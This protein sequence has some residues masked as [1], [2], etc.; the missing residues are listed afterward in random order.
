MIFSKFFNL[1]TFENVEKNIKYIVPSNPSV[2]RVID[3][4]KKLLENTHIKTLEQDIFE[5]VERFNGYNNYNVSL[6]DKISRFTYTNNTKELAKYEAS[7]Y[8][9]I[10]PKIGLKEATNA[11]KRVTDDVELQKA[12]VDFTRQ[13]AIVVRTKKDATPIMRA[14]YNHLYGDKENV[15]VL[16]INPQTN[17]GMQK[18]NSLIS[19]WYADINGL[20]PEKLITLRTD[21]LT[22]KTLKP[23]K[24][25]KDWV[26]GTPV[27]K[28]LE[29]LGNKVDTMTMD[30]VREL[31]DNIKGLS[32]DE[33]LEKYSL[34]ELASAMKTMNKN[35]IEPQKQR[36]Y[37]GA[38]IKQLEKATSGRNEVTVVIPDDCSLSG[39]SML[40]DSVKIFD[41][42]IKDNPEKKVHV[43]FSPLILGDMAHSAFG[44]FID[45]S[46]PLNEMFLRRISAIKTDG[47][48]AFSGAAKAFERVRTAENVT[49]EVTPNSLKAKHFTDTEYFKNLKDQNLKSNLLYLMQGPLKNGYP[50]FGGFGNCGT[51]VITPTHEFELAG[52]KYAGKI[53]TNSVGFMETIGHELGVL[54]DGVSGEKGLFTKGT[55]RGYSRYSEWEGLAYPESIEDRIPIKVSNDGT[56][57]I[58]KS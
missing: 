50:Q 29:R 17:N 6:P 15:F 13:E 27:A 10:K 46:K 19:G 40:C 1:A 33:I 18:S 58:R 8:R 20:S 57:S 43:V 47:S 28:R 25:H 4:G 30:K 24:M 45:K 14:Q 31:L 41:K 56:I 55:G 53:P 54:N 12:L 2:S 26:Q 21:E 38:L 49:F 22:T 44:T 37:I 5:K 42:F 3:T 35:I 9:Q 51:L 48:E 34:E 52:R 36:G 16:D 23:C 32:A 7:V 11:A 39:S